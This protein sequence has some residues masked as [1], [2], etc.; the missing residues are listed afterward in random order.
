MISSCLCCPVRL[1]LVP[2]QL[3]LRQPG[4]GELMGPQ[5]AANGAFETLRIILQSVRE[6]AKEER[7]GGGGRGRVPLKG[8]HFPEKLCLTSALGGLNP[9]H[10]CPLGRGCVF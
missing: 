9:G 4:E 2:F 8:G 7:G 3:R 1:P 6:E 5:K 10:I